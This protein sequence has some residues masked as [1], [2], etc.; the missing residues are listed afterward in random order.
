MSHLEKLVNVKIAMLKK[1]PKAEV[2][3]K[4]TEYMIEYNKKCRNI[5]DK[6]EQKEVYHQYLEYMDGVK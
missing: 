1:K 5:I 2:K 6:A 3:K 4:Y